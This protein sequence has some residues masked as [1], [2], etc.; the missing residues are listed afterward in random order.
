MNL[1]NSNFQTKASALASYV[2]PP[3][4]QAMS[5]HL[6]P[7]LLALALLTPFAPAG[8]QTTPGKP[9]SL[10]EAVGLALKKNFDIQIQTFTTQNARESFNAS[11]AIFDP[12]LTSSITRSVSQAA[13]NTSRLDGAQ[14]EGPA[15]MA[16][17]SAPASAS[18]SP[19][20]TA[21]SASPPTSHAR[22]PIPPT[23][24]S[25]PASAMVSPPR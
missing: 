12:T 4:S 18:A 20:P 23:P 8:A 9:L 16:P 22:P 7:A 17:P 19:P 2:D 21:S 25:I 13:S 15:T 1:K 3:I 11:S 14:L 6:T 10:E 24:C 5:R